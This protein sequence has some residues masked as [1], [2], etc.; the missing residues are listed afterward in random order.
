MDQFLEAKKRAV[1]MAS[2]AVL[3][4]DDEELTENKKR[5]WTKDW[6]LQRNKY[7]HMSLLNELR[8]NEQN[9]FKNYLRMENDTFYELLNLVRPFIEKQNTI[10]RESITAEERL[11]ATLRFLATGR[12]YEDLYL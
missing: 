4:C 2:I 11:V 12:S 5:K 9:D 1:V 8:I 3:L 6:L 10:M 7:S